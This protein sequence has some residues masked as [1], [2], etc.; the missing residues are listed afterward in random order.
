[1]VFQAKFDSF[2]SS[3]TYNSISLDSDKTTVP[4]KDRG[5]FFKA[6]LSS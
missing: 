2:D 3:W 5:H 4:A 6:D 1:M